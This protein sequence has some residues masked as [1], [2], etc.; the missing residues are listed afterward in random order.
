MANAFDD[1]GTSDAAPVNAFD[2]FSDQA[3]PTNA[4]DGFGDA[5]N[6]PPSAAS[7]RLGKART[8]GDWLGAN[9]AST[10]P[11]DTGKTV[12]DLADEDAPDSAFDQL[13]GEQTA[14]DIAAESKQ[15]G[16]VPSVSDLAAQTLVHAGEAQANIPRFFGVPIPRYVPKNITSEPLPGSGFGTDAAELALSLPSFEA[17]GGPIMKGV[18]AVTRAALNPLAK[19]SP[20][21]GAFIA[22]ALSGSAGGAAGLGAFSGLSADDGSRLEAAKRG[23]E[24]G[25]VLGPAG[26]LGSRAGQAALEATGSETVAQILAR[27]S[28]AGTG[29]AAAYALSRAQGKTPEEAAQDALLVA[30]P[31]MVGEAPL[32]VDAAIAARNA[33]T[34]AFAAPAGLNPPERGTGN[35]PPETRQS[36]SEARIAAD[37]NVKA[38][39]QAVDDHMAKVGELSSGVVAYDKATRDA[40]KAIAE[41]AQAKQTLSDGI[42]LGTLS[43]QAS[44]KLHETVNS[45]AEAASDA[46]ENRDKIAAQHAQS[47]AALEGSGTRQLQLLHTLELAKQERAALDTPQIELPPDPQD[48]VTGRRGQP[49]PNN[50]FEMG[51]D[52]TRRNE[53][54]AA[55]QEQRHFEMQRQAQT[56]GAQLEQQ[57]QEAPIAGEVPAQAQGDIARQVNAPREKATAEARAAFLRGEAPPE[58]V[59]VSDAMQAAQMRLRNNAEAAY[60]RQDEA[61]KKSRGENVSRETSVEPDIS[62]GQQAAVELGAQTDAPTE[63]LAPRNVSKEDYGAAVKRVGKKLGN[64]SANPFAEAFNPETIRDIYTVG[65]YHFENGLRAFKP[66]S[67]VMRKRFGSK[68]DPYLKEIH[69]TIRFG[70]PLP[71]VLTSIATRAEE[72]RR[73]K[74]AEATVPRDLIKPRDIPEGQGLPPVAIPRQSTPGLQATMMNAGRVLSALRGNPHFD[75]LRRALGV[76]TGENVRMQLRM[77]DFAKQIRKEIPKA[78]TREAITNYAEAGGNIETLKQRAAATTYRRLRAGYEA[79]THLTPEEIAVSERLDGFYK[80]MHAYAK[81]NGLEMETLD[82]YRNH[83]W[84]GRPPVLGNPM[85]GRVFRDEGYFEGEQ[86]GYKPFTKDAADLAVLY[87]TELGKSINRKNFV[88]RLTE[89]PAAD[90]KPMLTEWNPDDKAHTDAYEKSDIR[91]VTPEKGKIGALHKDI[92]DHVN[93]VF[94]PSFFAD[95]LNKPKANGG[96]E[97]A[98]YVGKG[99]ADFLNLSKQ[100]I[101]FATPFHYRTLAEHAV[102]HGVNPTRAL[103]ESAPGP[104]HKPLTEENY[105]QIAD[106]VHHTVT[107][108]ASRQEIQ[109]M[110]A[111]FDKVWRRPSNGLAAA[112]TAIPRGALNAAESLAHMLH[113]EYMPRLKIQAWDSTLGRNMKTFKADLD[114]GRMDTSDVKHITAK[115]LNESFG[116][117]NLADIGRNKTMQSI[118]RGLFLAPDFG[119]ARLRKTFGAAQGLAQEFAHSPTKTSRERLRSVAIETA[120]AMVA[121]K[122]LN[123]VIDGEFHFDHPFGIVHNGRV[124]GS[125]ITVA[126]IQSLFADPARFAAGRV[127]PLVRL[128]AELATNK[129]YKGEQLTDGGMLSRLGVGL[130]DYAMSPVPILARDLPGVRDINPSATSGLS[131][132]E[133]I[134]SASGAH[135]KRE[136]AITNAYDIVKKWRAANPQL[137]STQESGGPPSK[138]SP[139]KNA[140]QDEDMARAHAEYEKLLSSPGYDIQRKQP[141]TRAQW[142]EKVKA[143]FDKSMSHG[144]NPGAGEDAAMLHDLKGDDLKTAREAILERSRIKNRFDRL[145]SSAQ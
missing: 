34:D 104:W 120:F 144:F 54:E 140:L 26:A 80:D 59:P 57:G 118:W 33:K 64:L 62:E 49:N 92:A 8:G 69:N 110:A 142:A 102:G 111:N 116:G 96:A 19:Y 123:K 10:I 42:A 115:Q 137:T 87:G 95:L 58:G 32:D 108:G 132:M 138:Y 134:L 100:F 7:I 46:I 125:R 61:F 47:R 2:G 99:L 13:A 53:E 14:R 48:F 28:T 21:V 40:D 128:V 70:K 24:L 60:L 117:L 29:G 73:V 81:E 15:G 89:L 74:E 31:G 65:A 114:S 52:Q 112:A 12:V 27:L 6:P 18:G 122:A 38:A 141:M 103:L 107:L 16:Y 79:A 119:E 45:S 94:K 50:P 63:E 83:V 131:P 9:Q 98:R 133:S 93:N 35:V 130:K 109:N 78:I 44:K 51:L 17:T 77:N 71:A 43:I 36:E 41:H 113:G 106:M 23:A 1:F 3:T 75:S 126:D 4:F 67:E 129:N 66:W 90:G 97:A 91:S 25:A 124:Y 55:A 39:Q 37:N 127:S 68:F 20:R 84:D 135:V 85:K 82:N 72:K 88:K 121:M 139:L 5:T 11:T 101:F 86:A 145:G 143:G 105:P 76:M 136:N 30:G 56:E 22:D